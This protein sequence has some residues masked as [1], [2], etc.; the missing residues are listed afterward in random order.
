MSNKH[1][2]ESNKELN[3]KQLRNKL[4][5]NHKLPNKS[6]K[7]SQQTQLLLNGSVEVKSLMSQNQWFSQVFNNRHKSYHKHLFYNHRLFNQ[8]FRLSKPY[9]QP[10]S[11]SF[12]LLL[13][14]KLFKLQLWLQLYKLY[15]LHLLHLK[16]QLWCNNQWLLNKHPLSNHHMSFNKHLWLAL[17][18]KPCQQPNFKLFQF[19]NQSQCKTTCS[20]CSKCSICNLWQSRMDKYKIKTSNMIRICLLT[21]VNNDFDVMF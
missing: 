14:L 13:W 10:Y 8:L 7:P 17:P 6:N 3:I 1:R 2:R 11:H 5:T 4:S 15:K 12:K 9:N 21:P 20:K 16:H 19:N 18:F